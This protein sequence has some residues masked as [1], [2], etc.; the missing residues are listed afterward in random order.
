MNIEIDDV[1]VATCA[2]KVGAVVVIYQGD[3]CI[4]L[5]PESMRELCEQYMEQ[6]KC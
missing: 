5:S 6:S 2:T 4:E 1:G 3:D